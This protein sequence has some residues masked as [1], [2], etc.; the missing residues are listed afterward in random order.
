MLCVVSNV[1]GQQHHPHCHHAI[2]PHLSK[3]PTAF[4]TSLH[5]V[6]QH[7]LLVMAATWSFPLQLALATMSSMVHKPSA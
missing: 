1:A 6:R 4:V 2:D 7:R 5:Q 3:G